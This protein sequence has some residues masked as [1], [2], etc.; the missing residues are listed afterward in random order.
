MSS[1]DFSWHPE[2]R[3]RYGILTLPVLVGLAFFCFGPEG[4]MERGIAWWFMTAPFLGMIE[5]TTRVEPD[6]RRL[7]R[8]WRLL[9]LI[10]LWTKQEDLD[11]FEAVTRRRCPNR[12][13]PE[14]EWVVLVRKS[15]GFVWIRYFQVSPQAACPAA[16]AA[17]ERLSEATGLPVAAYQDRF[18]SK[19]V[20]A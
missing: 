10:P 2:R 8:Q 7:V 17:A 3:I 14:T 6:S 12:R 19:S 11:A 15:G 18:F 13:G 4:R 9:G 20:A 1:A 16:K 5:G